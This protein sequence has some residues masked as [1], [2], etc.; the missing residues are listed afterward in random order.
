MMG[1][2]TDSRSSH[3]GW[4]FQDPRVI[5]A[6]AFPR[7]LFEW[8]RTCSLLAPRSEKTDPAGR[9]GFSCR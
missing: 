3:A 5:A 9:T 1:G 2:M 7:A 4:S 8:R 6:S